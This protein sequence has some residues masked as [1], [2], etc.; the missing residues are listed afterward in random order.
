MASCS[1][2]YAT[3]KQNTFFLLLLLFL[4]YNLISVIKGQGR[5]PTTSL[6]FSL[7]YTDVAGI[8]FKQLSNK[9]VRKYYNYNLIEIKV[10]FCTSTI[11]T[12]IFGLV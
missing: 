3:Q 8:K 11:F 9:L 5:I 6:S 10:I 2:F 7:D 12:T 1:K 4:Y